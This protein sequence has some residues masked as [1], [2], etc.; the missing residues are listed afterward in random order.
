MTDI[1]TDIEMK[2]YELTEKKINVLIETFA[3]YV[4]NYYDEDD[5]SDQVTNIVDKHFDDFIDWAYD[6]FVINEEEL[7]IL[8]SNSNQ[9]VHNRIKAKVVQDL[10]FRQ[11]QNLFGMHGLFMPSFS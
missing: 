2:K 3:D 10:V 8:K 7:E 9:D 4:E 6:D 1:R 11:A 5:K